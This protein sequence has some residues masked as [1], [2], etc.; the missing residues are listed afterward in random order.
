MTLTVTD[1][2]GAS[3]TMTQAVQVGTSNQ[4]PVAAFSASPTNPMVNAWVQFDATASADTDGTIASYALVADVA[5]LGEG[6]LTFN[7]DGSYS[8]D[9]GTDF[10]DLAV[11]ATR[12]VTFT[13]TATDNDGQAS[14]EQTVTITVTGTN[15]DPVATANT[16]T[17]AED[18]VSVSG[19]MLTDND[20]AGIDSDLDGDTLTLSNVDATG[21]NQYGTLTL[22]NV[23]GSYTYAINNGNATVQALGLE[24][25][26][27]CPIGGCGAG[28]TTP[29]V[30]L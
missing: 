4:S 7:A 1:D 3:D 2:D 20:G 10:D 23:D 5:A 15:D 11:D 18:A 12:A 29:H 27:P 8:F 13:Y 6:T 30:R 9:P 26:P 28:C 19:N 14:A 21:A 16:N 17:I 22:D 24:R 25:P